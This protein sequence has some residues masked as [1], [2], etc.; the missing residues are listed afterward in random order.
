M[1]KEERKE[2]YDFKK[3]KKY[4]IKY[5]FYGFLIAVMVLLLLSGIFILTLITV[6]R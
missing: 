1:N 6:L 4:Q 2:V 3:P 5:F